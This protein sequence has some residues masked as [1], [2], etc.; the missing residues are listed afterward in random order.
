[1]GE[2]MNPA[3][4]VENDTKIWDA[5]LGLYQTPAISVALEL[6]IFESLKEPADAATLQQ[7][8][9]YSLRGLC[10]L[11]GMLRSLGLLDRRQNAYQLNEVSRAYLL[12]ES[13]FFWG[14]FFARTAKDLGTHRMLL[15]NVKENFC[16]CKGKEVSKE[17]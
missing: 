1:M 9:R 3:L 2:F 14:P 13:P 6:G 15:E 8:T 5:W 4:P 11:L 17:L 10:A 7:R 16:K 12:R